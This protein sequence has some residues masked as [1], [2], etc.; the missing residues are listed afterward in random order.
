MLKL[1]AHLEGTE[2]EIIHSKEIKSKVWVS[3]RINP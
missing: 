3:C 2:C 1:N